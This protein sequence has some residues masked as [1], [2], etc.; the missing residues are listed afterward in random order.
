MCPRPWRRAQ[1]DGV[2]IQLDGALLFSARPSATSIPFMIDM[3]KANTRTCSSV[4]RPRCGPAKHPSNLGGYFCYLDQAHYINGIAAGLS[5]TSNKIGYIAAKPI[6]DGAAQR[7]QLHDGRAD[8]EPERAGVPGHHG[9]MVPAGAGGRGRQC[10][11]QLPA[12]TSS[13]AMSTARRSCRDG[14]AAW[15]EDPGPQRLPGCTGS[16]GLHHRRRD[17]VRDGLQVAMPTC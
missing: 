15:R 1:D 2:M 10:A 3:A 4:T 16:Q 7:Q 12:A 17:Q 9:R 6:D 8:G 5:T 14:G 11:G 13:P